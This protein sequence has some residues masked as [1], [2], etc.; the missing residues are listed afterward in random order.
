MVQHITPHFEKTAG[1][2]E[3]AVAFTVGATN[4]GGI[5]YL[6][7]NDVLVKVMGLLQY[8]QQGKTCPIL[9]TFCVTTDKSYGFCTPGDKRGA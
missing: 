4:F 2:G 3:A 1:R 5:F 7:M 9:L 8:L 6:I